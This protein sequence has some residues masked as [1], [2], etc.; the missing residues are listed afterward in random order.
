M[1][2]PPLHPNKRQKRMIISKLG[3]TP[4]HVALN[5]NRSESKI[6]QLLDQYPEAVMVKNDDGYYP[7]VIACRRKC[8]LSIITRLIDLH[9]VDIQQVTSYHFLLHI[10][11]EISKNDDVIFKLID[12]FPLSVKLERSDFSY[13]GCPLHI[14]CRR[15]QSE[16]VILRLI[17]EYPEAIKITYQGRMYPLHLV[18]RYA[19][20]ENIIL[21]ILDHY[22]YAATKPNNREQYPLHSAC[23][24]LQSDTVILKLIET[25]PQAVKEVENEQSRYPL[26]FALE[27]HQ[28]EKVLFKLL[29]IY[30]QAVREHDLNKWYPLH[31]A[32]ERKH[33]ENVVL[34]LISIYPQAA[35]ARR[36]RWGVYPLQIACRN[37]YSD[38]VL[39]TLIKLNL[40][41]VDLGD[42]QNGTPLEMYKTYGKSTKI[43][44]VL[45]ELMKMSYN[46]LHNRIGIPDYVNKA[47]DS[48]H[49]DE[50]YQW[51]LHNTPIAID[52]KYVQGL[53]QEA[54]EKSEE[55]KKTKK[56]KSDN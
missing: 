31:L 47:L 39:I 25:S 33:S 37:K 15:N 27:R 3:N 11:C 28:S 34:R 30:P 56:T 8:P 2:E 7:L 29:D 40:A 12:T 19:K 4:V 24:V 38:K 42:K 13:W 35:C 14:S 49:R 55:E 36:G 41:A 21:K 17:D 22:P 48:F 32:L 44:Q 45:T 26:H 51:L 18:C 52:K 10:A 43:I 50:I 9:T 5:S 20:S 23:S 6:L 46:D 53:S 16:T 54:Y 1:E